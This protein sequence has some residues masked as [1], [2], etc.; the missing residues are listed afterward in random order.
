MNSS[1]L[2]PRFSR[3]FVALDEFLEQHERPRR[4]HH[5]HADVFVDG[6]LGDGAELLFPV[7]QKGDFVGHGLEEA[8]EELR[9]VLG[10]QAAHLADERARIVGVLFDAPRQRQVLPAKD[11]QVARLGDVV[12]ARAHAERAIVFDHL[13][14]DGDDLPFGDGAAGHG[15][16]GALPGPHHVFGALSHAL[17][18]V[19]NAVVRVERHARLVSRHHVVSGGDGGEPVAPPP[20]GISGLLQ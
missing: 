5:E 10:Q 6:P 18:V 20:L 11:A 17:H 4:H 7:R 15:E 3:T 2:P 14:A 8:A 19:A 1:T 13:H 9:R 12:D 16:V